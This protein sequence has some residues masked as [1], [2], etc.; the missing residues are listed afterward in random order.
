MKDVSPCEHAAFNLVPL[1]LMC[2][3]CLLQ[4]TASL[5]PLCFGLS[6]PTIRCHILFT[7][8]QPHLTWV[9]KAKIDVAAAQAAAFNWQRDFVSKKCVVQVH[10]K[11]NDTDVLFLFLI[12][13]HGTLLKKLNSKQRPIVCR[14]NI[15]YTR[16]NGPT[17]N[18]SSQSSG[19]KA[20]F[21]CSWWKR[22]E[23]TMVCCFSL[24]FPSKA[25]WVVWLEEPFRAA[26]LYKAV[27][28]IYL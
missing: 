9:E 14:E 28:C 22:T 15:H 24:L 17:N 10:C 1:A 20:S 6:T 13:R 23:V 16:Q 7:V 27:I 11:G 26:M 3:L 18:S 25:E 5:T 8:W 19:Y 21:Y 12:S 2:L 4:W